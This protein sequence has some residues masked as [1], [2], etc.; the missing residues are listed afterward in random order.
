VLACLLSGFWLKSVVPEWIY[1]KA[2]LIFLSA[3]ELAYGIA[4]AAAILSTL[5]VGLLFFHWKGCGPKLAVL[6]RPLALCVSTLL[7]SIGAETAC[8]IW[9]IRAHRFSAM[10]VGGFGRGGS[11]SAESRFRT[12]VAEFA[13]RYDFPD[14]GDDR[15]IDVVIMGESSAVGV[16]FTQ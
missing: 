2:A 14:Q 6:A 11:S 1:W 15:D 9:Q 7:A 4:L 16:P 5:V 13:L 12:P 8:A 10:P 3:A